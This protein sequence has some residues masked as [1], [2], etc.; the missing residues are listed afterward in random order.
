MRR[1]S[2]AFTLAV[3]AAAAAA[4]LAADA[5]P[6]TLR[7]GISVAGSLATAPL[8]G[9]MLLLIAADD[10][11]EPRFQISDNDRTAQVF[12][13]DA[14]G[15]RPG[16]ELFV[17][18]TTLGYPVQNLGDL[19]PGEYWVQGLL[20]V[21]ETFKRSDGHTVKLPPDRGE[22]Q[23]WDH[24]PGNLYSAPRKIR[25]DPASGDAIHL[26][27]DRKIPPLPDLPDTKYVRRIRF[28]SERLT[29]FWGRPTY[30]GALV[31]LPEGWDTHPN[32]KYPV[33]ISHG[34]FQPE[35]SSRAGDARR[36]QTGAGR[37]GRNR[38]VLPERPRRGRLRQVRLRADAA[39]VWLRVLQGMDGAELPPRDHGHDSARQSV[40][41]DWYA[42]NSENLGP[43]GDA[44]TYELLPHIEQ[45]FR[46]LGPW[47]RALYGGSTGGWEA[48]AA[49][50]F[51]PDQYNGA[52]ANCPDPIDF[53]SYTVVDIYNDRN[54]YYSEVR[55]VARHV[56][57]SA[58][59][60]GRRASRSNRPI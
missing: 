9:R 36:S 19:K 4:R 43:Y 44:I 41:D 45:T 34:H 7:V 3:C 51:Y 22:G 46:G 12:G 49:Q 53:R 47:A 6:A 38:E 48:L 23:Q 14:E 60:S 31:L 42:V 30:L 8:D 20:H 21:Y 29:K 28:Q 13:V 52:W 50:V 54:A 2:I 58:I 11:V 15:L 18:A 5:A 32:A 26:T 57:A 55:S 40:L 24:A 39:G 37:S 10:R 16:Q 56:P 1:L 25:I 35:V 27:L 33:A 17:D 59:T